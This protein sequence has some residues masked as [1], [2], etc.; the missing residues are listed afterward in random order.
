MV[1]YGLITEMTVNERYRSGDIAKSEDDQLAIDLRV[2]GPHWV[3]VDK[4]ML[5]ANGQLIREH[6]ID[7]AADS[8]KQLGVI[9]SDV[10]KLQ[11]PTHDTHLVAIAIGPGID[12]LHWRTAKPYQPDT[13]DPTTHVIGSSGAIWIDVDDDGKATS[14]RQY[15]ERLF[16]K[17]NGDV[18]AFLE[19]LGDFDTAV[20]AQS[21]NLLQSSGI[22]LLDESVAKAVNVAKP[23]VQDGFEQFIEAWRRCQFAE[24]TR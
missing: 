1:S 21:A 20:A 10:W 16:R 15:A 19:D 13:T 12:S 3:D 7:K 24:A 8:S 22:S 2:L 5:F 9:W 18:A 11:K 23:H 6:K 14:A 4:V 17:S